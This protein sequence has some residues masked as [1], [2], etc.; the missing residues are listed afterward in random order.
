MLVKLHILMLLFTNILHDIYTLI[1]RSN[2]KRFN[3]YQQLD[4]LEVNNLINLI[5]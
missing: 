1:S 3:S 4:S 5:K 2:F